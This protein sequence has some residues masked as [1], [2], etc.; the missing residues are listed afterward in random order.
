MISVPTRRKQRMDY[1]AAFG[2]QQGERVL[3]DLAEFCHARQPTFHPD[4][5]IAAFNEGARRVFLRIMG[6]LNMSEAELDR[7]I[8]DE[9][10]RNTAEGGRDGQAISE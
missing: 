7:L 5:H 10:R 9:A 8:A 6:F 4:P 1:R 2:T 3:A